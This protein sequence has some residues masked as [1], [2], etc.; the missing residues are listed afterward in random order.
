MREENCG[1]EMIVEE[2]FWAAKSLRQGEEEED[3]EGWM[4][5]DEEDEGHSDIEEG[6][7]EMEE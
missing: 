4:R 1:E 2:T 7:E 6:D 3:A 5:E